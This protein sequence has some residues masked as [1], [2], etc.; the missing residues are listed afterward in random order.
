MSAKHSAARKWVTAVNNQ[1]EFGRWDFL[2]CRD[3]KALDPE[4][5]KFASRLDGRNP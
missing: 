4:I 2:V 1:G 3:L 5:E